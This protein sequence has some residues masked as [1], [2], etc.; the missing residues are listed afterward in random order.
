MPPP[1]G[2]E[3]RAVTDRKGVAAL[4]S[5]H[6]AVFGGDHSALGD[7]LLADLTR[8]PGTAAAVVAVARQTPV[9]AGRVEFH[10]GTEFAS[11][12][13]GGTLTAWRRR[14]VFRSLVAYGAAVASAR[15]FSYLRVDATA[16]R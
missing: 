5:V 10:R 6:D 7:A 14:G 13:G 9:A 1:P 16:A 11:L 12:W 8:Q 4:V 2:V 3:L 15:G